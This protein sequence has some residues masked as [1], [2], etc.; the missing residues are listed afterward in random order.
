MRPV[1]I[2]LVA[3]LLG[4]PAFGVGPGADEK[5]EA[6]RQGQATLEETVPHP[7]EWNKTDIAVVLISTVGLIVVAFIP[8]VLVRRSKGKSKK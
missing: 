5:G 6:P 3:C 7:H 1:T 2:V 4:A 8:I